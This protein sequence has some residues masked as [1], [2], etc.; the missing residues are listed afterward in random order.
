MACPAMLGRYL[1]TESCSDVGSRGANT[2]D[3]EEQS[4]EDS[5]GAGSS[6]D[7]GAETGGENAEQT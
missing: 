4:K 6:A 3:D 2:G 7:E 5:D 1:P